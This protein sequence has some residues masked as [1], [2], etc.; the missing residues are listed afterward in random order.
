MR[1]VLLI[2]AVLLGLCGAAPIFAGAAAEYPPTRYSLMANVGQSYSPTNDIDYVTVSAAALFDYDRVWAHRAPEALRF[3]VEGTAGMTTAPRRRGVASANILALCF[4]DRWATSGLRPYVEAGI[5]VIYT[6]FQVDGQGLR[7][8]FNPQAGVGVEFGRDGAPCWFA[9]L[10][11]QHL[12]N[13]GL[14]E[15]N[16]GVNSIM[17]QFGRFF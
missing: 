6:D 12:S 7:V 1:P 4:L 13:G 11:L 16:R 2:L 8:N 5:G 9:A 10:R 15:D 14:H 3:K 17:A